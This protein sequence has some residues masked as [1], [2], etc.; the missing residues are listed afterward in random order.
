VCSV[1]FALGITEKRRSP[2]E[3]TPWPDAGGG[4]DGCP[5]M[6]GP[7]ET[8]RLLSQTRVEAEQAIAEAQYPSRLPVLRAPG[9]KQDYS[10]VLPGTGHQ[11]I[12][13]S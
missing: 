11:R 5:L 9:L 7:A 12:R 13:E 4:M 2:V 3:D 1:S 6:T 10:E 8:E